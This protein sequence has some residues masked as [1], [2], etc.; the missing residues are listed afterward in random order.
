M[1]ETIVEGIQAKSFVAFH[2]QYFSLIVIILVALLALCFL[3][4]PAV[5]GLLSRKTTKK[6][7]SFWDP[8]AAAFLEMKE[9]GGLTKEE[10][11][12]S[13]PSPPDETGLL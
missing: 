3:L 5:V 12:G 7:S 10:P 9:D 1:N 8:M 4:G 2:N 13:E 6:D 11:S